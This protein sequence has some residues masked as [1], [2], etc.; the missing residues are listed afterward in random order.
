MLTF[1]VLKCLCEFSTVQGNYS[2]FHFMAL[3][4][5]FR[6]FQ[7]PSNTFRHFQTEAPAANPL[8]LWSFLF[9]REQ[10]IAIGSFLIMGQSLRDT[11]FWLVEMF[12]RPFE[13]VN[14]TGGCTRKETGKLSLRKFWRKSLESED[15]GRK[16]TLKD[17]QRKAVKQLYGK[18]D[19][20]NF[21]NGFRRESHLRVAGVVRKWKSQWPHSNCFCANN[22]PSY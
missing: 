8:F 4:G 5:T 10:K 19:S 14:Q 1:V 7:T 15:K 20:G 12:W 16:I 3:S 17:E 21:T 9:A 2:L 18:K 22:L 13:T 6:H 11:T